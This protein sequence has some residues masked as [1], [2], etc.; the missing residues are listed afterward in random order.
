M[1]VTLG[2]F[3]IYVGH[4]KAGDLLVRLVRWGV[5]TTAVLG[6]NVEMGDVQEPIHLNRV[7]KFHPPEGG[8]RLELEVE[9]RRV[10]ALI[11]QNGLGKESMAVSTVGVRI[12]GTGGSRGRGCKVVRTQSTWGTQHLAE[13]EMTECF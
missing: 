6:S 7:L 2:E 5:K 13:Q 8:E 11:S 1:G 9:P 4:R 10:E 3:S 12:T